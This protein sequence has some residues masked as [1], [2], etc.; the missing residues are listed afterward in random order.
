MGIILF[1]LFLI[2]SVAFL[3]LIVFEIRRKRNNAYWPSRK[4][5][6]FDSVKVVSIWNRIFF[7]HGLHEQE[8][9]VYEAIKDTG[10]KSYVGVVE[11]GSGPA[12]Y[13]RDPN[14]IK[15]IL[16]RFS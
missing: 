6:F 16:V 15:A 1:T 12:F 2:F 7:K 14:L 13:I 8:Q 9:I 5:P 10:V 3:G 11:F 4:V